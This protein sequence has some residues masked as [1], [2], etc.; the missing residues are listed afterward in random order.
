VK[1]LT[2]GTKV[3]VAAKFQDKMRAK[4]MQ[5]LLRE[6]GC[7]ITYA[8]TP[9]EEGEIS[10]E[11]A[12]IEDTEGV[13]EADVVVALLDLDDVVYLGALGEVCLD[14][15]MGKPF[16]VMG[17]DK[18]LGYPTRCIFMFHPLVKDLSEFPLPL[19]QPTFR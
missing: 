13:K 1:T 5:E 19:K 8:W 12:A 9:H 18:W 11:D 10:R 16:Y 15:A 4:L 3:Y 6:T 14:I 2:L 7:V 17:L